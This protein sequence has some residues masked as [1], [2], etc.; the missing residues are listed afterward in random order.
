MGGMMGGGGGS[1]SSEYSSAFTRTN[2]AAPS[3]GLPKG[4]DPYMPM[5]AVPAQG[6]GNMMSLIPLPVAPPMLPPEASG[7]VPDE[8]YAQMMAQM[9]SAMEGMPGP[10]LFEAARRGAAAGG[11]GGP[12]DETAAAIEDLLRNGM[13]WAEGFNFPTE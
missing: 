2:E 3:L 11:G 13:D 4:G 12:D 10:D 1:K 6:G 7:A 9:E 5:P 8:Q